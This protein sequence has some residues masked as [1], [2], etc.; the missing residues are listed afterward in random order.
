MSPRLNAVGPGL[1]SSSIGLTLTAYGPLTVPPLTASI[2]A[3]TLSPEDAF[4][5]L[6]EVEPRRICPVLAVSLWPFLW[7]VLVF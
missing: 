7:R 2:A 4:G 3:V 5:E 6:Y 1:I